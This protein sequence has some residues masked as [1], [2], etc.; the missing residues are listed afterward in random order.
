MKMFLP[1]TR[2]Y[3]S[4]V[5]EDM[6]FVSKKRTQTKKL[7]LANLLVRIYVFSLQKS[8]DRTLYFSTKKSAFRVGF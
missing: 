5:Y 6:F 3:E 8:K 2:T 1:P 7:S 4:N